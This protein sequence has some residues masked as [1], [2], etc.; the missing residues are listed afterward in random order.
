MFQS[1]IA[2]ESYTCTVPDLN[3]ISKSCAHIIPYFIE[4]VIISSKRP[5]I[6]LLPKY[7]VKWFCDNLFPLDFF[8]NTILLL[9]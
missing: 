7:I 8:L 3:P 6:F 5:V 1:M 4:L 9:K 2:L